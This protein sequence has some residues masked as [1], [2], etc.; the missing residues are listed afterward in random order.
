MKAI[1]VMYDSLNRHYLSPYGCNWTKTP[2]FQR[3]ATHSV[4][5][6]NH[7][8]GSMPCMP[9]RRELHTGRYNFLHRGWSP[10]E[11][12]DDSMPEILANNGIYTH[13]VSDHKHYWED[14]GATYH[15]RY[16]TWE[17][18]R[19]QQG[20]PWKA[21][22][23]PN[24]TNPT[25]LRKGQGRIGQKFA[26]NVQRQ[27][28]INRR[29]MRE[30]INH[31]QAKTF[32]AGLEF[33][34][35]NW[36]YDNWFLQI[37]TFDPHEPFF[38]NEKYEALYDKVDIG[39]EIDWP[40]YAPLDSK[41]TEDV[42]L[43]VKHKYAALVSMCDTYLGKVLDFMDKHDMWKD[44]MLI[45][46]TDHGF[47]IGEHSWWA[48]TAMPLYNEIA[49]IPMFIWDPRCGAMG[50]RRS[51]LTQ[52]IDL[53]PTLLE[54]F[55]IERTKDML[56]KALRDTI[57]ND[58]PVHNYALY[59]FHGNQINITD[60]RYV[61]MRNS[62]K[63]DAPVYE[64][65]L[66]PT[67]MRSRY[68]LPALR[69][70]ELSKPFSF[71]KDTPLLKIPLSNSGFGGSPY[72]FGTHLFDLSVDPTQEHPIDDPEIEIQMMN[73][74]AKLMSENDA[75]IHEF[76]R[77]GLYP[78]GEMSVEYLISQRKDISK[79]ES[80]MPFDGFEWSPQAK[81]QFHTLELI[82]RI[83]DLS[84]KFQTFAQDANT[85]KID[86]DLILRFINET[87]PTNI[88][89]MLSGLMLTAGRLD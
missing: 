8:V 56:G 66:M 37:E 82:A 83:P 40:P 2:N 59:G 62:V 58:I 72:R 73:A 35:N 89:S 51:S 78:E 61:Y 33:L 88:S 50:E 41:D 15:T 44:T 20:D 87:V 30:E 85:S 7:Y 65:T 25:L 32:S 57:S 80:I 86:S 46:N 75:P 10:L 81:E 14:G 31:S 28:V 27:D 71:T 6:D 3:L 4:T 19:G 60:G 67:N 64:Y 63:R 70:S 45:V 24:I 29:Y 16:C 36:N 39:R 68:P 26:G 48:K 53:A 79:L 22:L 1:M 23:N 52:T 55:G 76:E 77:V 69:K 47:L 13:L 49:H 34:E 54:F 17:N 9:A 21:D 5:F 74:M 38:S 84:L 43:H 12:F 18:I 11:P 42:V